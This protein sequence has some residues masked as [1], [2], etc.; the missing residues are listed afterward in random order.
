[1]SRIFVEPAKTEFSE[2]RSTALT[3]QTETR[4]I[5][6]IS[7]V[8]KFAEL[9][10][11]DRSCAVSWKLN[12]YLSL[13]ISLW[14]TSSLSTGLGSSSDDS[15]TQSFS[16]NAGAAAMHQT[17]YNHENVVLG[18]ILHYTLQGELGSVRQTTQNT[19]QPANHKVANEFNK[20]AVEFLKYRDVAHVPMDA[21]SSARSERVSERAAQRVFFPPT[22]GSE[23]EITHAVPIPKRSS[24]RLGCECRPLCLGEREEEER[25]KKKE[26]EREICL[27]FAN[28]R[29]LV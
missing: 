10:E 23:L 6:D 7:A 13:F 25:R 24:A 14:R 29:T 28:V 22:V 12:L 9:S 1:M 18:D 19:P 16:V 11:D 5:Y 20:L 21:F 26:R 17:W 3:K 8:A 27:F 2:A 15:H 4:G